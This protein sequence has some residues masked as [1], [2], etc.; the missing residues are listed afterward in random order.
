M[1]MSAVRHSRNKDEKN[2]EPEKYL[3]MNRAELIAR[4]EELERS[5]KIVQLAAKTGMHAAKA[6]STAQLEQAAKLHAES[7][8]DALDSER[9]ANAILTERIERL[10]T[11]LRDIKSAT[12][13]TSKCSLANQAFINRRCS[14]ALSDQQTNSASVSSKS[15]SAVREPPHCPNCSCGL[16]KET[17]AEHG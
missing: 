16:T 8:P 3:P 10:E 14:A 15:A 5:L 17:G 2:M 11:A 9:A 1:P 4:C 13:E 7:S 12:G 6:I